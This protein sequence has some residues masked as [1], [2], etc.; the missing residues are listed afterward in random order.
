MWCTTKQGLPWRESFLS[1]SMP[2]SKV[3]MQTHKPLSVGVEKFE[4]PL[5]YFSKQ[6]FE[7]LLIFF[8]FKY[9]LI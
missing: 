5:P 7:W 8:K 4:S 1:K 6:Y 9:L 3:A 2:L